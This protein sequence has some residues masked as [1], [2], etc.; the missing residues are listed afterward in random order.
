MQWKKHSNLEGKHAV[1]APS[2]PCW[3]RYGES[4]LLE[5]IRMRKAAEQ[6]TVLHLWAA[7]TIRL[8]IKQ[9][10]PRGKTPTLQT[11]V[12]DAIQY[13]MDPEVMLYYSDNCFGTADAISYRDGKLRIHDLKTGSGRIHPEQLVVYAALFCL[14][15]NEA[16]EDMRLI[17]LRVYQ[18][19]EIM[20]IDVTAEDI[21]DT[22][23]KI[24][25]C[26]SWIKNGQYLD[27]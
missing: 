12:N 23:E 6:G 7:S 25:E 15:Y 14:E 2:Q 9:A 27:I 16:P 17:E 19:D 20:V 24:K 8:G 11:Y 18:N 13:H 21:R 22:M 1:L 4:R 26:D 5:Y 3:V 10:V